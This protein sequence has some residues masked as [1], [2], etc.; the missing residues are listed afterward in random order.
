MGHHGWNGGPHGD[1][2]R[3][4]VSGT[5]VITRFITLNLLVDVPG[6]WQ[7]DYSRWRETM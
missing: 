4:P 7:C 1:E 5:N 3:E 6:M 2:Y